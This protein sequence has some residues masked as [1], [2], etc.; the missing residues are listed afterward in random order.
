MVVAQTSKLAYDKIKD[1]LGEKQQIVYEALK[2][3]GSATN[4]QIAA[5]LGWPINRV[6]GR[7]TELRK[8]GLVDIEGIGLS[9]SG[10]SAKVWSVRDL[11][12]GALEKIANECAE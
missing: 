9:N 12:D 4:D 5:K 6:T 7:V 11:N 3:L 1:K 2:E 8:Y 10:N